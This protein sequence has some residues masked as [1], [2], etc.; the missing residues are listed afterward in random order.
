MFRDKVAG[1]G[2][3]AYSPPILGMVRHTDKLIVIIQVCHAGITVAAISD[4]DSAPL[5]ELLSPLVIQSLHTA[6]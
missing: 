2:L 5:Q 1:E 4:K 3:V 6:I